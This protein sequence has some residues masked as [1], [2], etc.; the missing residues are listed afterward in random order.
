MGGDAGEIAPALAINTNGSMAELSV[1]GWRGAEIP[2]NQGGSGGGLEELTTGSLFLGH[3][4]TSRKNDGG[5]R[6][7]YR[8]VGSPNAG[9]PSATLKIRRYFER[10]RS[11]PR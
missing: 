7:I 2:E 8:P 11:H 3:D 10:E 9:Q 6:Q 4:E 1:R 5:A